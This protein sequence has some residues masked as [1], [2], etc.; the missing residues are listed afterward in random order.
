MNLSQEVLDVYLQSLFVH[1]SRINLDK[2]IE[3]WQETAEQLKE[4]R[5]AHHWLLQGCA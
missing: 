1:L 3:D 5:H 2:E 4:S